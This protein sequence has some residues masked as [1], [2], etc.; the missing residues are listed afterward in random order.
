M[1]LFNPLPHRHLLLITVFVNRAEPDQAALVRAAYS[2]STVCLWKYDI[3]DPMLVDLT[4]HN[5]FVLCTNM[6]I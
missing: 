4:S 6:K 2:G 3:S 1:K 5:L